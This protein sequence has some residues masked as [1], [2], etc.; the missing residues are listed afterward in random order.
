[1]PKMRESMDE[2]SSLGSI[3][4]HPAGGNILVKK[5]DFVGAIKSFR[6]TAKAA[7]ISSSMSKNT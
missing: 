4:G 3:A 2:A 1:M 6:S 5:G 7:A